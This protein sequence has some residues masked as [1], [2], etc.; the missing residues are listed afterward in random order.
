MPASV[1]SPLPNVRHGRSLLW[2]DNNDQNDTKSDDSGN[3]FNTHPMCPMFINQTESKRLDYEL[4]RWIGSDSDVNW[5]KPIKTGLQV[6]SLS[7]ILIRKPKVPEKVAEKLVPSKSSLNTGEKPSFLGNSNAVE[8]FS[9]LLR[10]HAPLF[11]ALNRRDDTFYVVWFSGEHL[12]VPASRHNNT[13]RPRMSL[14]LPM[15]GNFTVSFGT[16]KNSC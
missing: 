15:N 5:T 4:R 2:V 6:K 1:S 14:V 7:E 13:A 3:N 8:V 10:E 11:E 16:L 12:L 9:P